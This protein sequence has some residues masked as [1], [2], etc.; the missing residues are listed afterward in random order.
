ML[1]I[2]LTGGIGSGK[3]ATAQLFAELGVPIIDTDLI[4]RQM[5]EP[6]QPAQTEIAQTFGA[7]ILTSA[8]QLNRPV[9]RQLIFADSAKRQQLEAILHPRIQTEMLRQADLLTT[10][11]AIFVIPLLLETGQQSLVN[12][13]LVIDCDDA[14]RRQRL[15]Q[16][17]QMND[18]EIDRAFAAQASREQRLAA[19]DETISNNGDLEQLRL[20]VQQLHHRYGQLAPQ[21]G[22]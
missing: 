7:E 14:I 16:R 3:S 18:A 20:Q 22:K 1:I 17:E 12:R 13:I 8:G 11:Y 9:L 5:V 2:G 19:A 21:T 15:K 10:P 6:G 4:A